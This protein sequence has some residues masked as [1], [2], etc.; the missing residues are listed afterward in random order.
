M[1][2]YAISALRIM[3]SVETI[4]V[5]I[6]LGL[7]EGYTDVVHT[8]DEVETHLREEYTDNGGLCVTI[9]P[10]RFVYKDG[11]EDGVI[12]GFINYPRFPTPRQELEQLAEE[13]A[14]SC[15]A[16]FKQNG[17]SVEY[18]DRTILIE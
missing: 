16:K 12:I 4:T 3:K 13:V 10:T 1:F 18:Q 5:K 8:V 2:N 15:K 6:Y 11:S 7:R 9:T 17:V 14:I